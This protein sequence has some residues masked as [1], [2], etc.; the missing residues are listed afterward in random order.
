MQIHQI[1]VHETTAL[2]VLTNYIGKVEVTWYLQQ[3]TWVR[4]G[5]DTLEPVTNDL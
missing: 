4:S 2:V 5:E 3:M 1:T